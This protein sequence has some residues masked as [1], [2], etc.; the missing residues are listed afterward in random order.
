MNMFPLL[1]YS[2]SSQVFLLNKC[3]Q[4]IL[5][6]VLDISSTVGS[7]LDFGGIDVLQNRCRWCYDTL[8]FMSLLCILCCYW[9]FLHWMNL[10]HTPKKN[11]FTKPFPGNLSG[12]LPKWFTVFVFLDN[13]SYGICYICDAVFNSHYCQVS[14][15]V[16]DVYMFCSLWF[17]LNVKCNC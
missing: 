12:C 17:S 3:F 11:N 7:S 8:L 5:Q 1:S 4:E 14:S 16:V 10:V 9:V 6:D 2:N 15:Y 13:Q